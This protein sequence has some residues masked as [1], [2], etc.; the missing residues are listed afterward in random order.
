MLPKPVELVARFSRLYAPGGT[1]PKW[2]REVKNLGQELAL[3][4]NYYLNNHSLKVQASWIV[5]TPRDASFD[6]S[7][8]LVA[9]HLDAT[10]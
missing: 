1:D 9:V 8:H 4:A 3:G 6:S 5:R 7:D 2:I 10:F